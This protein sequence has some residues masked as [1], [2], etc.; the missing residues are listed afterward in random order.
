MSIPYACIIFSC[1]AVSRDLLPLIPAQQACVW[2]SEFRD[3]GREGKNRGGSL[4]QRCV[5]AH[6]PF[7]S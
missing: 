3:G 6:A 5:A 2:V 4:L 7:C 1:L